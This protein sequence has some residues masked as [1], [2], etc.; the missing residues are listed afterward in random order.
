MDKLQCCYFALHPRRRGAGGGGQGGGLHHLGTCSL[1][2]EPRGQ[3]QVFC[4]SIEEGNGL[5]TPGNKGLES[6]YTS[7]SDPTYYIPYVARATNWPT[8]RTQV[9]LQT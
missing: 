7:S 3:T 2:S 4:R 9:L 5:G 8:P 1:V 6:R